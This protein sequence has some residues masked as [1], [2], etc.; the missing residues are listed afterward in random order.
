MPLIALTT[1]D[2]HRGVHIPTMGRKD[3]Q[4]LTDT[5]KSVLRHG[6]QVFS[7]LRISGHSHHHIVHIEADNLRVR[8]LERHQCAIKHTRT[9]LGT[10]DFSLRAALA[11]QTRILG[12]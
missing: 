4:R 12:S 6:I 9:D 1:A 3:V 11:G 2:H 8:L 10:K 7:E 5:F